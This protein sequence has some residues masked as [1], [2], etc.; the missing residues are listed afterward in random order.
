MWGGGGEVSSS[1]K[2]HGLSYVI[3]IVKEFFNMGISKLIYS[4][5]L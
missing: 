2:M 1:V 4:C 3:I 5:Y